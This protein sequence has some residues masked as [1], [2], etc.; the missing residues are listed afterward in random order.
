MP[1]YEYRCLDCDKKFE[2]VET[3]AEHGEHEV[4]CPDCRKSNI[5]RIWSRV[6]A[7]TSKKS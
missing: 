4:L 5:E 7:V 2:V 6:V 3:M 1:V